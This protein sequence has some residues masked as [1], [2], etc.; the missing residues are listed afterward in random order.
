MKRIGIGIGFFG[1]LAIGLLMFY[2]L[3]FV[4][5]P[6]DSMSIYPAAILK[7]YVGLLALVYM[8]KVHHANINTFDAIRNN[9][10]SYGLIILS[11]SIII[12]AVLL[13]I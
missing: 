9:N 8:D 10:V 4:L 7:M 2:L 12:S 1:M 5:S 13:S 3:V 6:Y 11:Y